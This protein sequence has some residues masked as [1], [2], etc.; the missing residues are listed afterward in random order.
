[1]VAIGVYWLIRRNVPIGI[2]GRPASFHAKGKWAVRL[3]IA[4]IIFGFV[5]ALEIINLF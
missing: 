4:A 2:E 5:V 3:S 1:M